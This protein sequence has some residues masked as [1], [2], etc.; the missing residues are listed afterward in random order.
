MERIANFVYDRSKLII[1]IVVIINLTALASFFRFNLN[2]DFLGFF[3]QGN[4]RAEEYHQL[5]QKYQTGEIISVL[6]EHEDSLLSKDN[7]K[8]VFALQQEIGLIDDVALVQSYIPSEIIIGGNDVIVDEALIENNHQELAGFIQNK[9]FLK[10]QFISSGD[11]SG[12]II[13]SL[14]V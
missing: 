10:E 3:T 7:M 6:I 4:P 12:L 14:E 11:K 2:T 13:V 9:F 1:I 8:A 5:N